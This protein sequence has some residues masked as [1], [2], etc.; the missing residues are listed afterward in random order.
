M[1][2]HLVY[3]I[4]NCIKHEPALKLNREVR[5]FMRQNEKKAVK[6]EIR[7]LQIV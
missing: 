6:I 3:S 5:K 2:A 4:E 1:P 7:Q